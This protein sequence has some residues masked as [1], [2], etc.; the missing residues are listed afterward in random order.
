LQVEFP[1]PPPDELVD[2]VSDVIK[3]WC[4]LLLL[5]GYP[6]EDFEPREA[7]VMAEGPLLYDEYTVQV[8]FPEVFQADDKAFDAMLNHLVCL[9]RLGTGI[10]KVRIR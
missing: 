4:D 9:T 6:A 3:L 8:A 7:G 5:G 2:S 10:A 1:T